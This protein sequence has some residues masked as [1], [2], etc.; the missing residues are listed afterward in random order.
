[1]QK[2]LLKTEKENQG[3]VCLQEQRRAPSG[4]ESSTVLTFRERTR[5]M[6][7]EKNPGYLMM[8]LVIF[9]PCQNTFRGG[10][11]KTWLKRVENSWR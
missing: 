5:K 11:S 2:E 8:G 3:K 10:R 9:H 7:S 4:K 6:H 1:M